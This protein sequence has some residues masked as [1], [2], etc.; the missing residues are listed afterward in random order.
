MITKILVGAIILL[1][2]STALALALRGSSYGFSH[3]ERDPRNYE[4]CLDR[5][6][7]PGGDQIVI[8][9]TWQGKQFVPYGAR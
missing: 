4:E 5:G 6:G 1:G 8:W 7:L 9:C 3:K 2:I